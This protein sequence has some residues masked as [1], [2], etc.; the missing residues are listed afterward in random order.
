MLKKIAL[1]AIATV[2]LGSLCLSASVGCTDLTD[3]KYCEN[4]CSCEGRPKDNGCIADCSSTLSSLKAKAAQKGCSDQYDTARLCADTYTTCVEGQWRLADGACKDET[5]AL[6]KC[7]A[8]T[9]TGGAGG[10]SSTSS[11]GTGG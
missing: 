6:D 1:L 5:P 2:T 9:G 10:A 11:T 4:A 7:L 8:A 3:E